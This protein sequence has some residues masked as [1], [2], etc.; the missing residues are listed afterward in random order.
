MAFVHH[1]ALPF[2]SGRPA[3]SQYLSSFWVV[4][5]ALLSA[6]FIFLRFSFSLDAVSFCSAVN[7]PG[8]SDSDL[9]HLSDHCCSCPASSLQTLALFHVVMSHCYICPWNI[10]SWFNYAFYLSCC[11][12][13]GPGFQELWLLQSYLGEKSTVL[14]QENEGSIF[15][16]TQS[17]SQ[18]NGF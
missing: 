3:L 9:R 10:T 8:F 6:T 17:S 1:L 18:F 4:G 13:L 14:A 5:V 15:L 11:C 2:S 16:T 7:S 12:K